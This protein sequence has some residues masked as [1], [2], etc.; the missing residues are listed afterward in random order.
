MTHSTAPKHLSA[1]AKTFWTWATSSYHLGPDALK[2]LQ[3]ACEALD[4]AE[5]A[6]QTLEASGS[7]YEDRHGVIRVHPA[8]RVMREAKSLF[9]RSLSTLGLEPAK[10]VNTILAHCKGTRR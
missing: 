6:R 5:K 7:Y 4:V 2:V 1:D 10:S 3:T 9:L 8:I